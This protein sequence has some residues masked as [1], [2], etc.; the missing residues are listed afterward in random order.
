MPRM[1]PEIKTIFRLAE[2]VKIKGLQIELEKYR[3]GKINQL[4]SKAKNNNDVRKARACYRAWGLRMGLVAALQ[5]EL[6][7][8]LRKPVSRAPKKP[9]SEA[10]KSLRK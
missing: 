7:R 3:C 8:A 5:K 1:P 10:K 2:I 4:A 6:V 9:V